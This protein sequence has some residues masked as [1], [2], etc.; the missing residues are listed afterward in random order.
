MKRRL[1]LIHANANEAKERVAQLPIV[2]GLA[3]GLVDFRI[4]AIDETWSGL[5][6][7]RRKR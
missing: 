3:N 2:S 7:S 6:F 1:R 4:Y 5:K